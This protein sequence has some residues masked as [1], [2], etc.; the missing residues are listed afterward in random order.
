[1]PGLSRDA[2]VGATTEHTL[3]TGH[4][5]GWTAPTGRQE[6]FDVGLNPVR[7]QWA[8]EPAPDSTPQPDVLAA[9]RTEPEIATRPRTSWRNRPPGPRLRTPP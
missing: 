2:V 7:A 4:Q 1:M 6:H 5:Q 3:A 9:A 8:G